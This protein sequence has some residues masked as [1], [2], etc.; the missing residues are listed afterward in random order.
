MR[1]YEFFVYILTDI[2][3][4]RLYVGITNNLERRVWEHN[5]INPGRY[6]TRYKV[7]KLVYYE[8]FKY[9]DKAIGREKKLKKWKRQWK[10]D[11]INRANPSWQA[12][13]IP[14]QTRSL[15]T[16]RT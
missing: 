14:H 5:Q 4:D 12:L 15:L 2:R 11:L 7:H 1:K 13:H 6:T 10:L 8:V 3:H 16:P 9:V